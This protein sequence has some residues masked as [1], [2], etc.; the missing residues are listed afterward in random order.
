[1]VIDNSYFMRFRGVPAEHNTPLIV[2]ADAVKAPKIATQSLKAITWRRTQIFEHV[3]GVE[4]VQLHQRCLHDIRGKP[5]DPVASNTMEEIFR[6][7]VSKGYDHARILVHSR[8]L[9]N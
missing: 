8:I 6:R 9:C 1:M 3:G 7:T 2:D 5:P 4:H